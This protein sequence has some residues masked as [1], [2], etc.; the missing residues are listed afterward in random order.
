[1]RCRKLSIAG[2]STACKPKLHASVVHEPSCMKLKASEFMGDQAS[3][4]G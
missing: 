3:T 2:R 4:A 1:M